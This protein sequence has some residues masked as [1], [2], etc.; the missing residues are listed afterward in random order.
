MG[1]S[2]N[3]CDN[4][5]K[6][7]REKIVAYCSYTA[8]YVYGVETSIFRFLTC[9]ICL[10]ALPRC[11]LYQRYKNGRKPAA[12]E[13]IS[14][15]KLTSPSVIREP[16]DIDNQAHL[17][18][19]SDSKNVHKKYLTNVPKNRPHIFFRHQ[20]ICKQ[21]GSSHPPPS[22]SSCQKMCKK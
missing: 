14:I 2:N 8:K 22:R 6:F 12:N 9:P 3:C 21:A 11:R 13:C 4:R 10:Y 1:T 18:S 20:R 17:T 15:Y 16:V 7:Q 19:H 5:T